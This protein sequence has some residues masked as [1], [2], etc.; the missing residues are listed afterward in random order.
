MISLA[1]I[2]LIAAA[3]APIARAVV[4]RNPGTLVPLPCGCLLFVPYGGASVRGCPEHS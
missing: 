1:D 2:S 3:E 4:A